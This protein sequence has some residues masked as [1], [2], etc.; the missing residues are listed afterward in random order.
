MRTIAILSFLAYSLLAPLCAQDVVIN[1][2]ATLA[3]DSKV[4]AYELSDGITNQL[5]LLSQTLGD[6]NGNF[7]LS[8]PINQTKPLTLS[9]N[10]NLLFF[11]PTPHLHK[12]HSFNFGSR[13]SNVNRTL[14]LMR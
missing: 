2:F 9:R 4:Y 11:N 7:N 12:T 8:L 6:E 10:T 14:R 1:G 13:E 5:S 3:K